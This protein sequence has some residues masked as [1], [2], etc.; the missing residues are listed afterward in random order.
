M[1]KQQI[2]SQ[3][4]TPDIDHTIQKQNV[5]RTQ[6]TQMTPRPQRKIALYD[7]FNQK[8]FFPLYKDK[9][10][11]IPKKYQDLLIES[12]NDDD[13]QTSSTQMRR[14]MEQTMQDLYEAYGNDDFKHNS[15]WKSKR[16]TFAG[17]NS[18]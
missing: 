8:H 2:M 4:Q 9:D 5:I 17:I 14:G 1:K 13:K 18:E 7:E 11:G 15:N 10:L 6:N 12:W 3:E 16:I